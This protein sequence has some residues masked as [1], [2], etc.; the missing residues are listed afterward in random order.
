MGTTID[1]KVKSLMDDITNKFCNVLGD[2][3]IGIYLH[4]SVAFGCYN[5]QKSDIDFI[6]VTKEAPSFEQK[7]EIISFILDINEY[8]PHKGIEMSF[9]LEKDCTDFI[10][11]TPYQLHFS[12]YHKT[13]YIESIDNHINKL[14]GTD[15][16][17][18]AHFTVINN[19]GI[20][21]YGKNKDLVFS[22]VPKEYYVDSIK[23]DVDSAKEDIFDNPVYIILNLCRVYA[24][25]QNNLVLSKKDGGLWGMENIPEYTETIEK[26][27]NIYSCNIDADFDDKELAEFASYM[28]N[29]IFK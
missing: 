19:V 3:L 11:P 7:K 14:Q 18:A 10:S 20:A 21:W 5:P 25:M 13:F 22:A 2:N 12:N 26:A 8:A 16:D 9:V 23:F 28:I 29:K 1:F 15:K 4:G 24:Y 27:Y 17:L 6:V